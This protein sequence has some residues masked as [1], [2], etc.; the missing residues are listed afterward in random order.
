[1]ENI[2]SRA[3]NSVKNDEIVF[4]GKNE[5]IYKVI[6]IGDPDVGKTELLSKFGTNE[7]EEKY[8]PTVG[9]SILKESIELRDYNATVNLVFWDIAGQ[10]QFYMLHRPYFSE[11][12]GILLVFDMTRSSTFS[13]IN[14]WYSSAVKYGLSGIPRILIG[15]KAHLTEERKIILPMAERLAEKLNASYYETSPL[16]GEN[17]KEAFEKIAELIY[18]AKVLNDNWKKEPSTFKTYNGPIQP[19]SSLN[20]SS[21]MEDDMTRKISFLKRKTS[22]SEMD[23]REEKALEAYYRYMNES[24]K[25]KPHTLYQSKELDKGEKRALKTI[26]RYFNESKVVYYKPEKSETDLLNAIETGDLVVLTSK[27][28]YPKILD[29]VTGFV[30]FFMFWWLSLV[31]PGA[32]IA[33]ITMTI[34]LIGYTGRLITFA[35]YFRHYYI[36]LDSQGIYYKKIGTPRFISWND[37]VSINSYFHYYAFSGLHHNERAI[38]LELKSKKIVRFKEINY[39]YKYKFLMFEDA[40][41]TFKFRQCPFYRFGR[42]RGQFQSS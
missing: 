3:E 16:S 23:T 34:F 14:N 21:K 27:W 5:P 40:F 30:F 1:M 13:N 42:H 7:F 37:V 4:K 28:K 26:F 22:S 29:F 17:F 24:I 33:D 31:L 25:K 38:G 32:I 8:L 35:I 20:N 2:S 11:A 6:V 36:V 10:P 19:S 12:D 9:V 18:R 41:R 39:Q 15:N